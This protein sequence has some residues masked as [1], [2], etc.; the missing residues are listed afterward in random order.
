MLANVLK[1]AAEAKPATAPVDIPKVLNTYNQQRFEDARAVCLLS[2]E[3][4]G[5]GRSMRPAF[6][7]QLF[8]TVMLNK[9][10]G[11]LAPKVWSSR[12]FTEWV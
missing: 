5:G 6:A 11:L 12:V 10:L 9:T 1:S 4:L 3:A 2:E 7:A 8:L